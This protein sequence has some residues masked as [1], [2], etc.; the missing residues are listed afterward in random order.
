MVTREEGSRRRTTDPGTVNH[1]ALTHNQSIDIH[2]EYSG[3]S[4]PLMALEDTEL[5]ETRRA[6]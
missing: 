1:H 6:G 4:V 2:D 5:R 3:G